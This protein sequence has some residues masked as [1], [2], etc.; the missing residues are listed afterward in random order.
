MSPFGT[1]IAMSK[2]DPGVPLAERPRCALLLWRECPAFNQWQGFPAEQKSST[3]LGTFVNMDVGF[4]IP[5]SEYM[6]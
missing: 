5:S 4:M 6:Q 2:G 3:R 1:A